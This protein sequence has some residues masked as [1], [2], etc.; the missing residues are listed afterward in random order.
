[1][2]WRVNGTVVFSKLLFQL[3]K[4]ISPKY[5][6]SSLKAKTST[7]APGGSLTQISRDMNTLQ[8]SG[9][10]S[11]IVSKKISGPAKTL[12]ISSSSNPAITK[13]VASASAGSTP[14]S[15]S[16]GGA[17][18]PLSKAVEMLRSASASST[19]PVSNSSQSN[20]AST[21]TSSSKRSLANINVEAEYAARLATGTSKPSLNLVVVGHV[22]AGKS[23]TMGH[24]LVLLGNVND[25]VMK[26]YERDAEAMKKGS[27]AFAWVLDETDAERER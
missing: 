15:S 24:L 18:A 6:V 17:G 22:D 23:T 7:T 10:S 9:K 25:R 2:G 21:A 20:L 26:K 19:L 11:R 1:M 8:L 12:V 16:A 14:P 5:L 27:F 4:S 13:S 3:T